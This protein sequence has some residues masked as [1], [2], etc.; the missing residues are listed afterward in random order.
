MSESQEAEI[1]AA[2]PSDTAPQGKQEFAMAYD[3]L[4]LPCILIII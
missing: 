3:L 1:A 2:T 4:N